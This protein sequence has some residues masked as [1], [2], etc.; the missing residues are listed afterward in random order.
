MA[1]LFLSFLLI[2]QNNHIP[3]KQFCKE[4]LRIS[5]NELFLNHSAK[6]ITISSVNTCRKSF[7]VDGI[8]FNFIPDSLYEK[9]Q[10][11]FYKIVG[12]KDTLTI[13]FSTNNAGERCDGSLTYLKSIKKIVAKDYS[14]SIQ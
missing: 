6:M 4:L 11:N 10:I 8:L 5:K 12:N 7:V 13:H 14:C 2:H 1:F 3:S 9:N